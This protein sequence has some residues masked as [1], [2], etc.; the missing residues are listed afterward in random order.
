MMKN[1]IK[2]ISLFGL[3]MANGCE[4]YEP[5]APDFSDSYPAYVEIANTASITVPEGGNIMIVL[6]S[7]SVVY[8]AYTVSYEITGD[9][10]ASGTVEVP[11]GKNQHEVALP[12]EAGIVT[13]NSLS[14]TVTLTDVSSDMVLGRNGMNTSLD[15]N[16]T[17]FV[18]FVQADYAISFSCNEPGYG[19]YLCEFTV[20]DQPNVLV[21]N[22]F[23]D[24]GYEIAYTFSADFDQKVVIAP[25]EQLYGETPLTISGS[26][27]Y[28][29]VTKTIVVDYTVVDDTGAVW[30]DNTHTFTVPG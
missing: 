12:V 27:S 15:V 17:K 20:G 13:D 28:D 4:M 1:I 29:G 18:P 19:D 9:Y 3:I 26:G 21:N 11:G 14:A 2:T 30:D 10:A 7:R 16:I 22:N 8:D 23:W 6:T 5:A 24:S 25:Q